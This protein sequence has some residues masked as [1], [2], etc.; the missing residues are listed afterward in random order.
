MTYLFSPCPFPN[1]LGSRFNFISGNWLLES[2]IKKNII[3]WTR[4][5]TS[6]NNV[7]M[8]CVSLVNQHV[9]TILEG[10]NVEKFSWVYTEGWGSWMWHA[11]LLFKFTEILN[12]LNFYLSVLLW[13]IGTAIV[14]GRILP[15]SQSAFSTYFARVRILPLGLQ[16]L[17]G[18]R[19]YRL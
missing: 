1:G 5:F 14:N 12:F 2:L 3:I 18:F 11:G 9:F 8:P 19:F 13:N 17:S 10:N 16:G 4:S 15:E 6:K 7:T